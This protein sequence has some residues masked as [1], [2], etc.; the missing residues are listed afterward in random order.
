MH[1]TYGDSISVMRHEF[2]GEPIIPT[3]VID[4]TDSVFIE[5][6]PFLETYTQHI[7]FAR[8]FTPYFNLSINA[9]TA[10]LTTGTID[11]RIVTADT[12]PE[13]EIVAFVTIL[14]DSL[15]GIL[16]PSYTFD[17]VL[18]KMLQFPVDLVYPD[19]LDTTIVFTHDIPV[20]RMKT[21]IFIQDLNS[22]EVM[23]AI[24]RPFE[25]E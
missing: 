2:Y 15:P 13:G 17:H 19:S 16:E 10:S 5:F 18:R 8:G 4:G 11:L 22:K 12:I 21:V 7:D 3:T 6:P 9:A 1:A 14:E 25:E 23:Q 20:D 24:L